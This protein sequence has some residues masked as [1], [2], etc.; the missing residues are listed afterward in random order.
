MIVKQLIG[1]LRENGIG[2]LHLTYYRNVSYGSRVRY[3]LYSHFPALTGFWNILRR[4]PFDRPVMQMNAYDLNQIF[5]ILQ[6]SGCHHNVVRFTRHGETDG[7][8]LFFQKKRVG[9]F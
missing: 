7:V 6:E 1:L 3:W 9:L 5:R 8:M 2:V 4:R